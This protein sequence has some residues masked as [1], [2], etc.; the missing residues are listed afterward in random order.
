MTQTGLCLL[1]IM[2]IAIQPP[3]SC[4]QPIILTD[5]TGET[6]ITYRHSDGST[7][8]YRIAEGV[9]SGLASLDYDGDGDIDLYFISGA[10]ATGVEKQEIPRNRLY[11]NDGNWRFTDV[12]E[13][14]GVGDTGFS[15]GAATADYDN[16]GDQDIYVNND[17]PNRLYRNNGDGTF[18]DVA[19][20]AGVTNGAQMG[21]GANFLDIEGDG[22][23]DLFVSSYAVYTLD[24]HIPSTAEGHPIYPG[25]GLYDFT[26]E[27]L[28]RN[29]GDGTFTDIST[30]AGIAFE[31]S[32][33]MGTVCADYDND[34]D[35]DIF[36]A[37]DTRA[38]YLFQNDGTGR[39]EE[40]GLL[41]GVAY[42]LHG[43]TQGSMGLDL[44]DYDNDGWLDLYVTS[45]QNERASL[46]HNIQDGV[47]EDVTLA[48]GAALGTVPKVTWGAG[49]ADFDNNG[50]RDLFVAC[51]H[52]QDQIEQFDDRSTYYQTNILYLNLGN[53]RFADVSA[54]SGSG[55][56][57]K[58]ASRGI[59][60]D[61]FDNDGDVDVVIQ[62]TRREPTLLRN[63]SPKQGHWLQVTLQG[64][65]TNRDGIGA[66]VRVVTADTTF[67]DEVHSGRSYQS[68]FGRRLYFGLGPRTEIQRI[69]VDWIG[70]NREVYRQ[71]RC[72]HRVLL[73]EGEAEALVW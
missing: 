51:G 52:I 46:L 4:A 73:I 64:Q 13:A 20:H 26:Y 44:G 54:Q 38:N 45:Y 58:L 59:A 9:C 35:T 6:G 55:L 5:V 11:R 69:E 19:E 61:D 8:L 29:N 10:Y 27:A 21:A 68:D 67:L 28:F 1:V 37:N 31:R 18:T 71:I 32:P 41:A 70:G 7:G 49:F 30:A 23:L 48:S 42:D 39:F 53:G 65:R 43:Q 2:M 3:R 63:D 50:W 66:Q 34:G 40:V 57:V 24:K 36:T 22:D 14:A 17:G 62:N 47:F 12:T 60:L 25:P 15:L 16:D 33:G 56:R 72:D